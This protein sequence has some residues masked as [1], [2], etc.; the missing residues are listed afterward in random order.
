MRYYLKL[1]YR[2]ILGWMG[3]RRLGRSDRVLVGD[4]LMIKLLTRNCSDIH[5]VTR[6]GCIGGRTKGANCADQIRY[7]ADERFDIDTEKQQLQYVPS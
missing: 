4:A 6:A 5:T 2:S 7:N 1:K 3:S